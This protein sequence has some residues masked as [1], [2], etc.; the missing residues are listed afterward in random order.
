[1][2]VERHQDEILEN[3]RHWERKPLLRE[4]YR[5]FHREIAACLSPLDEKKVV[6]LGSGIGNIQDV[7]PGC[8]R[9][10]LFPNPWLDQVENAFTLSFDDNSIS[11]LILFDVFHHLRYPGEALQEF[12][13]V[14]RI[15]GRVM[16]FEPYISTLGA[17]VYGPM[18][19]EPIGMD[20]PIAWRAPSGWNPKVPEYYAAQG[21][22]TRIFFRGEPC[23]ELSQWR[24][25]SKSRFAALSYV[26]IGGYS[27][28]KLYPDFLYPVVRRLDRVLNHLPS[29]FATR[30]LVV[31]EKKG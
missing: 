17:I 21:N 25:V 15:G 20:E 24:V 29:I 10:D 28:P 31:L 13:R 23:A 11:D 7:I 18:H 5:E 12:C 26:A 1:M 3:A 27:G 14:L 16:I 4:I 30:C 8:L 22:V 2:S 6:E 9:T 19:A